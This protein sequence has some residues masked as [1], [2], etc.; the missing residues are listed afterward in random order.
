MEHL[1]EIKAGHVRAWLQKGEFPPQT[2]WLFDRL[3]EFTTKN[4]KNAYVL[5]HFEPEVVK[6]LIAWHYL[7]KTLIYHTTDG[8]ITGL[9]MWYRTN[10]KWSWEDILTWKADDP[11]GNCFF[12]AFL[13]GEG[14][15]LRKITLELI[16]RQPEVIRGKLFGCRERQDGPR[17]VEY[18]QRLFVKILKNH[19][20]KK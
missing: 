19:G 10:E 15:A 9:F 1:P 11:G 12:L 18:D 20:R 3:Y 6:I 17:I 14:E 4:E 8:E 2:A 16:N 7:K 13:W 5:E